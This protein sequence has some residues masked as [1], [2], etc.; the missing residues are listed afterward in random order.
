MDPY[1]LASAVEDTF[2]LNI[3]D[4]APDTGA[5]AD[6]ALRIEEPAT[7]D[8]SPSIRSSYQIG[9]PSIIMSLSNFANMP[10][11]SKCLP[12]VKPVS[13]EPSK[14]LSAAMMHVLSYHLPGT[15]R[16]NKW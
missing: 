15:V 8:F 7:G 1:N 12:E 16:L 2:V 9:A 4:E 5:R 11:I 13:D 3:V 6:V 14:V 10:T